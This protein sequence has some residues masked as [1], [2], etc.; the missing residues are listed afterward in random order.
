[1]LLFRRPW[2]SALSA[3]LHDSFGHFRP[4]CLE[5]GKQLEVSIELHYN[6]IHADTK[7]LPSLEHALRKGMTRVDDEAGPTPRRPSAFAR[8]EE[9]A[10]NLYRYTSRL[11]GQGGACDECVRVHPYT[12]RYEQT[13][14]EQVYD[15]AAGR[16]RTSGRQADQGMATASTGATA[17]SG[18]RTR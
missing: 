9:D 5:T 2:S 4:S 18:A 10:A 16:R 13:A 7:H 15:P 14:R 6:V 12:V 17:A 3:F 1:M 8:C 11:Q